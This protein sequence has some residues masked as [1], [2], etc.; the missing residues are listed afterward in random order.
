M[1]TKKVLFVYPYFY[2]GVNKDQLFPPIGIGM[3][4]AVLKKKRN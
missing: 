4:S 3:L 2:T 1:N